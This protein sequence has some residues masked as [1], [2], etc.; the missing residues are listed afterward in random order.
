MC[1]IYE[2]CITWL[3]FPCMW[4][5]AIVPLVCC[6]CGCRPSCRCFVA[7]FGYLTVQGRCCRNLQL[8]LLCSFVAG[9]AIAR[10]IPHCPWLVTLQDSK[11]GHPTPLFP[12]HVH[13]LRNLAR[14]LPSER[15]G[16]KYTDL[17][18]SMTVS[19]SNCPCFLD[20]PRMCRWS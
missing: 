18:I 12:Y 19:V 9:E 14:R 15:Y 3:L 17:C 8:T 2:S 10:I 5:S 1:F 4:L 11:V 16:W 20:N 7:G 13:I 6:V